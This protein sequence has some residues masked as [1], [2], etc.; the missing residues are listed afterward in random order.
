MPLYILET[1]YEHCRAFH[2]KYRYYQRRAQRYRPKTTRPIQY[3]NI[4]IQSL[5]RTKSEIVSQIICHQC[6]QT[7]THHSNH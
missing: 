3:R 2:R 4:Q 5:L 7:R 1:V 6:R